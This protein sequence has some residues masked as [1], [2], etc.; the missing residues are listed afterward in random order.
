MG[1]VGVVMVVG[2]GEWRKRR[3]RRECC[4]RVG[5]D[6]GEARELWLLGRGSLWLGLSVPL[7]E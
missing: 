5:E 6:E 4:Q 2:E 1:W 7:P 3:R